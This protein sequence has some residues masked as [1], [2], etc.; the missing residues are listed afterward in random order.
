MKRFRQA[1]LLDLV[2]R[3]AISS[4]DALRQR[5][6]ARGFEATQATIS[7][8]I[9]DLRLVKRAADG[10]YERPGPDA[11]GHRSPAPRPRQIVA[12]YLRRIDRVE[13]LLVLKTDAGQASPLAIAIDRAELGEVVG[14]VAGDDT[15]LVITRSAA[16]ARDVARLLETWAKE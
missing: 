5:L 4:Q 14:T 1:A 2:S 7:R 12:E 3:E 6:R 10:A 13:Q 16:G 15:I 9:K 11:A 8:D